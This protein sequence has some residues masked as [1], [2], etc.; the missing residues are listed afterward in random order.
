MATSLPADLNRRKTPRQARSTV[1]V[2]TIF[3]AT[4]QVLLATGSTRLNTTRV[5]HRAGVSV[6]T[7]YQYFPNKQALLLAV[8]ERH[9]AMLASVV[10]DA[11]LTHRDQ[12][13]QV[14]AEAVATAYLHAKAQQHEV[15]RALYLIA[16]E[17]DARGSVE[18]ATRRAEQAVAEMLMTASDGCFADAPLVAR[19]LLAA[20]FGAVRAL[21][22][23]GAPPRIGG[24]VEQELVSMCRAYLAAAGRTGWTA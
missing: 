10:E 2:E 19:V 18:A 20:I 24:D 11:C 4:I 15:S 1:T 3:D 8:L 6:G 9:L 16:T 14:M 7:L 17:L 22:E 5:S 23:Q 13:V 12:K 21:H